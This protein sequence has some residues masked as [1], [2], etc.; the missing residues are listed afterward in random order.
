MTRKLTI[1]LLATAWLIGLLIFPGSAMGGLLTLG[2]SVVQAASQV[3]PE[4]MIPSL[5]PADAN[6]VVVIPVQFT[7]NQNDISSLAFSVD[8]DNTW[9]NFN[10][11]LPFSITLNL[12]GGFTGDCTVD[13]NDLDGEIDCYVL[14]PITPISVL[15][16]GVIASIR[17]ETLNAPDGTIAP[18]GFST[19]PDVTF[20]NTQGQFVSGTSVDGSVL[21]AQ[22]PDPP[23]S[24]TVQ[25]IN[26]SAYLSW[27]DNSDDED[28]FIIERKIGLGS[29]Q[30]IDTVG[31]N[32]TTYT[33]L[34]LQPNSDYTYRVKS[35][36]GASESIASNEIQVSSGSTCAY[37]TYLPVVLRNFAG[38][39]NTISGEVTDPFNFAIQS[40]TVCAGA[41][42][43]TTGIFGD[44]ALSGLAPESYFVSVTK[45][46]L[47]CLPQ[48]A[49]PVTVPPSATGKDF[50]CTDNASGYSISGS[51]VDNFGTPLSN[52][53]V[54]DTIKGISTSSDSNGFYLLAG[55]ASNTYQLSAYKNGYS[56]IAGFP[57]PVTVPPSAFG[58][59]FVCSNV[60]VCSNLIQNGGFESRNS[61]EIPATEYTA[62]Y[63]TLLSHT[64]LSSMR[65]GIY[66]PFDNR[67]SYSSARQLVHIPSNASQATLRFFRFPINLDLLGYGQANPKLL[68]AEPLLG[69]QIETE[70]MSGDIQMVL[71]LDGYDNILSTLMWGL[72]NAQT[73][74]YREFNLLGYRG[75]TIKVYFGTFNDGWGGVSAQFVDDVSLDVCQ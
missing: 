39:G 27:Q 44:Y 8:Y 62:G 53:L 57:N 73:W 38:G 6:S 46:G 14:D 68:P 43:T 9:L 18:V 64:G 10:S 58:K 71:V 1:K 63:S 33:D 29:F 37:K 2:P 50:I 60:G 32:V 16:D 13:N 34:N 65:T 15:P 7:G 3:A 67:Y 40:A 30:Q 69:T 41:Y 19:D 31:A 5:I 74:Q 11:T 26:C 35:F 54:A 52:V 55:L 22:A 49:N 28:G 17:L 66:N 20:G 75:W 23:T 51:V 70:A 56:C 4:L 47:T 42:C 61:W 36:K 24:L 59:N 12:P 21:F 25:V 45:T 48:F 72:S